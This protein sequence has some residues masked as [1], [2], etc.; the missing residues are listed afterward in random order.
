MTKKQQNNHPETGHFS[1]S[2]IMLSGL[3]II[4]VSYCRLLLRNCLCHSLKSLRFNNHVGLFR[5]WK[6]QSANLDYS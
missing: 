5:V 2:K 3:H 4:Y 1:E 6:I